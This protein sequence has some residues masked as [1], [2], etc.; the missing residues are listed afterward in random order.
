MLFNVKIAI[1]YSFGASCVFAE[2]TLC[3]LAPHFHICLCE[4]PARKRKNADQAPIVLLNFDRTFTIAQ[5]IV[6]FSRKK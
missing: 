5:G 1:V 2:T 6:H 3:E 4:D